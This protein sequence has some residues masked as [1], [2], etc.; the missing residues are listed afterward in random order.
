MRQNN[1]IDLR[2]VESRNPEVVVIELKSERETVKALQALQNRKMVVLTLNRLSSETAQ[3]VIDWMAGGTHAIDG[4][5]L[6]IGEKTFL[7]APSSVR[8]TAPEAA[9]HLVS[10]KLERRKMTTNSTNCLP[11]SDL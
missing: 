11:S 3:R 6:W 10:P 8:I 2:G 1:L 4:R 5:T 7:F 9:N